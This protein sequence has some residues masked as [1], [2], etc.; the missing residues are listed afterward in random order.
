MKVIKY[1]H[2]TEYFSSKIFDQYFGGMSF[3]V[4]D[5][6]TL[7]LRPMYDKLV[8][9]GI[10]TVQSDGTCCLT[11]YFLEDAE[12]ETYML[13]VL[14]DELNK[15]DVILT[16]NGRHF[17][18]PFITKRAEI[19]GFEDYCIRSYN[20]DLYLIINGH[21]YF[22]YMLDNLRQST[23]EIYMGLETSRDD[24]ISGKESIQLY[25]DFSVCK[26]P[27]KKA[28]IRDR[29][30]LHNHDDILQLYKLLPVLLQTDMHSAM[31]SLGFPQKGEN[32]WPDLFVRTCRA[33]PQALTVSG[34]YSGRPVRYA[35]FSTP[36][37]PF[38]CEFRP[39]GEFTFVWPVQNLKG[40]IF[41]NTRLLLGE[42]P[43]LEKYAGYVNGF[44]VLSQNNKKNLLEINMVSK[45]LLKKFM[46]TTDCNS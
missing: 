21:S 28:A 23:V 26:D 19:L 5:I 12:E 6:E 45:E 44:I 46:N 35:S 9:A 40:N 30:L 32:G 36:E 17:D 25:L 8:L 38:Q 14:A 37:H 11:Q 18:V 16:Y 4:F 43:E 3:C 34:V 39:E 27:V 15:Y 1:E 10:M 7:G 13:A 22:R 31:N 20:L 29:I 24:D 2:K 42:T 33:T 41:I